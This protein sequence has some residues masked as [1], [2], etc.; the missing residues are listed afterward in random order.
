MRHLGLLGLALTLFACKD[1][2]PSGDDSDTPPVDDTAPPDEECPPDE[3]RTFYADGDGDGFGSPSSQVEACEAPPGHVEA[4]GDCDDGDGGVSPSALERCDARDNDCSGLV[5]DGVDN[6]GD[7]VDDCGDSCY[8]E[9]L[10]ADGEIVSYDGECV[11]DSTFDGAGWS[12]E[13]TRIG[14]TQFG[15][16]VLVAQTNDDDGDGRITAADIP[17][18]IVMNPNT[19][20]DSKEELDLNA[21]GLYDPLEYTNGAALTVYSGDGSGELF[22]Y[23]SS[24]TAL[25]D[26][27]SQDDSG[28]AVTLDADG[29]PLFFLVVTD[30]DGYNS[31]FAALEPDPDKAG[32]LRPR[33]VDWIGTSFF[34]NF[35]GNPAF[36]QRADGS[37][38]VGFGDRIYTL[39]GVLLA[40]GS[41]S[42]SSGGLIGSGKTISSH[43]VFA[44]LDGDGEDELITG[45]EVVSTA[46][47]IITLDKDY[48]DPAVGDLNGDGVPEIVAVKNRSTSLKVWETKTWRSVSAT[49]S[50]SADLV[51]PILAELDGDAGLEIVVSG[52]GTTVYNY[53]A[54]GLSTSLSFSV[55][56][57]Q[58]SAFDFDGDGVQTL[59]VG[60]ALIDGGSLTGTLNTSTVSAITVDAD[61]DGRVEFVT[62]RA[63]KLSD[64]G[65]FGYSVHVESPG[66]PFIADGSPAWPS[67]QRAE[68]RLNLD[69]SLTTATDWWASA[70]ARSGATFSRIDPTPDLSPIVDACVSCLDDALLLG[71]SLQNVGAELNDEGAPVS[72][73]RDD[74]GTLTLLT[75]TS[76][77]GLSPG[78]TASAQTLRLPVQPD[79]ATL[80][81]IAG[82][83]GD[84]TLVEAECVETNNTVTITVAGCAG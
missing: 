34:S 27:D 84:Q 81:I 66:K 59:L 24:S 37:P 51:P 11:I 40:T 43:V 5:D 35:V 55:S 50:G 4:A 25:G 3:E 60:Y 52:A 23:Y 48:T 12:G 67:Y 10:P 73:Y 45:G 42:T 28:V 79:G 26:F 61:G 30:K 49:V 54:T 75:T 8:F 13:V 57:K 32:G 33:W 1:D 62:L 71:V 31:Y 15:N 9:A 76:F 83:A 65:E 22:S 41:A 14:G 47:A 53:L 20:S 78:E 82:D 56:A 39:D 74:G 18:I 19:I 68:A 21:D 72:V 16:G 6:D 70:P 58:L 63:E 64:W 29:V 80:V 2:A 17:D 44:D 38:L 77:D 69:G 36:G 46:G 7:G